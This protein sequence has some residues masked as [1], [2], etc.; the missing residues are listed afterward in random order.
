MLVEQKVVWYFPGT[1]SLAAA[2]HNSIFILW[3]RNRQ[4]K[5]LPAANWYQS[6][7]APGQKRGY[8]PAIVIACWLHV[9]SSS[10]SSSPAYLLTLNKSAVENFARNYHHTTIAILTHTVPD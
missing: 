2:V 3:I 8:L 4:S 7:V 10:S 5:I 1:L 6:C 9:F